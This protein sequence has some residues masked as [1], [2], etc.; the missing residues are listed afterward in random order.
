MCTRD[1]RRSGLTAR[2][3]W[4]AARWGCAASTGFFAPLRG[5]EAQV[6]PAGK[7]PEKAKDA[8]RAPVVVAAHFE[9][10]RPRPLPRGLPLRLASRLRSPP[11]VPA[12]TRGA[13]MALARSVP[14]PSKVQAAVPR[15]GEPA[16]KTKTPGGVA[17]ACAAPLVLR[18]L[19]PSSTI[20]IAPV[21]P[22]R[23]RRLVGVVCLC[24]PPAA[25]PPRIQRRR[26]VLR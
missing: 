3:D 11:L 5:G 18:A 16:P 9:P 2:C 23:L 7:N 14:A 17:I 19:S 1:L 13:A 4:I 25:S 22:A 8:S 26:V 10:P 24:P 6:G 12:S 21:V 15:G 20:C